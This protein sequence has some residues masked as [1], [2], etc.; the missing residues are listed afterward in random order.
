MRNPKEKPAKVEK[1]QV[2]RS[3]ESRE[4]AIERMEKRKK[5]L[6]ADVE[7]ECIRIDHKIAQSRVLL[8]AMKRGALT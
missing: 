5:Q 1:T 7:A 3:I 6:R 2:Q 4:R 8:D